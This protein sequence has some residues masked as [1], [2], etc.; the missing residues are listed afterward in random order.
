MVIS[1]WAVMTVSPSAK[2]FS[3]KKYGTARVSGW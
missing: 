3:G 1:W 2:V